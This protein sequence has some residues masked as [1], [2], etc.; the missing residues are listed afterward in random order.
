MSH[1]RGVYN[2]LES[3]SFLALTLANVA[4]VTSCEQ[5]TTKDATYQGVTPLSSCEDTFCKDE[6]FCVSSGPGRKVTCGGRCIKRGDG[7]R[8]TCCTCWK[9]ELVSRGCATSFKKSNWLSCTHR[10][11]GFV[12]TWH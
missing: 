12:Y 11:A 6:S 9:S 5:V 2:D 7:P 1:Q 8:G 3:E 10:C 4:N